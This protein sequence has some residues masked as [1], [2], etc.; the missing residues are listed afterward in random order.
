MNTDLQIASPQVMVD[1]DR[2][3]ALSLG[4]TPQ[5]IQNALYQRLTATRAGFD[6]LHAGES[7][8]RSSWKCSRNISAR[9]TRFRSSTCG[10]RKGRWC[11]SIRSSK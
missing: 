6:D 5:Q 10:R 3:R 4:V 11:R 2:D 8:T 7:S 1:I 9:R